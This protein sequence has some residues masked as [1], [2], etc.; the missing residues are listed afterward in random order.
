MQQSGKTYLLF[1]KNKNPGRYSL[2]GT[3]FI[4]YLIKASITGECT[5]DHVLYTE[6]GLYRMVPE[7][8]LIRYCRNIQFDELCIKVHGK[9]AYTIENNEDTED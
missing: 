8:S 9:N 4:T 7:C 5:G 1:K 6:Q 2:P 3:H